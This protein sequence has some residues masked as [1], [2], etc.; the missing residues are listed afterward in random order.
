M[1]LKECH[2]R[3][4]VI[5]ACFQRT[6]RIQLKSYVFGNTQRAPPAGGEHNQFSV[7]IRTL[8]TENFAAQ[9]ME[10]TIT[11][12]LRTLV[13]EHRPDIPQTLF[14][15]VQKTMLDAGAYTARRPFRAQSQAVAIAILKGVHLFFN[16]V[17]DFTNRTFE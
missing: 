5:G 15:I 16:H 14:L 1:L 7:D 8:Q 2:Q 12:F 4:A 11:P 3:I 10:L 6:D 13:T 17:G 9:L